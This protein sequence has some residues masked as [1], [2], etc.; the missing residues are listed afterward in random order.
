MNKRKFKKQLQYDIADAVDLV[1]L[2]QIQNKKADEALTDKK[3]S[4]LLDIYDATFSQ[5]GKAK[6]LS[7][8]EKRKH[9]SNLLSEF[10]KQIEKIILD[11]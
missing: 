10:D 5:I 6:S 1:I 11:K 8:K 2:Q 9:F 4:A 7:T 3:V